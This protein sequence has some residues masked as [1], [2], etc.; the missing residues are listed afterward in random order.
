MSDVVDV[1]P[2]CVWLVQAGEGGALSAAARGAL[3]QAD[4]VLFDAASEAALRH[5]LPAGAVL[6]PAD[7]APAERAV[8]LA[9]LGWRVIH[10]VAADPLASPVGRAEALAL[11]EAGVGLRIL[12]ADARTPTPAAC[13]AAI[14]GADGR[15]SPRHHPAAFT[16]SGMG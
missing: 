4:F 2:G 1:E 16:M 14:D 7:A 15:R 8:A 9:M 13:V 12:A 11:A 10:L 3:Q 6:E 5:A